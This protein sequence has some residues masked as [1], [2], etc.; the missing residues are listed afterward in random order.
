MRTVTSTTPTKVTTTSKDPTTVVVMLDTIWTTLIIV[1]TEKEE[2]MLT[3]T[4][5]KTGTKEIYE[6]T[7]LTTQSS[8]KE[9][10]FTPKYDGQGGLPTGKRVVLPL[11]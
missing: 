8:E 6:T 2:R 3:L 11:A 9:K 4:T 7:R 5:E 1:T 10:Q